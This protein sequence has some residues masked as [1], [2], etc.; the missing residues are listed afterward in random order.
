MVASPSFRVTSST[1]RLWRMPFRSSA[2]WPNFADSISLFQNLFSKPRQRFLLRIVSCNSR[3][4]TSPWSGRAPPRPW[5]VLAAKQTASCRCRRSARDLVSELARVL[6]HVAVHTGGEP[7]VHGPG[8]LVEFPVRL[9]RCERRRVDS[10]SPNRARCVPRG[11]RVPR[12]RAATHAARA[13]RS[14]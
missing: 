4:H 5:S 13:R 2:N 7:L 1:D 11:R 3:R 8:V 9:S 10:R 14:P 12:A 6:R